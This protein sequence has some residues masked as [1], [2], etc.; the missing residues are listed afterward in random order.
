MTRRGQAKILDFG[1]AKLSTTGPAHVNDEGPTIAQ[2]ADLT[3]RG[4]TVGT[5]AY[6]S[7]EQ[8]RRLDLDARTDLFSFGVVLYEMATGHQPF[9]GATSAVIFEG[10]LSKAPVSPVRLNAALPP[11]LERVIN[12]AL[13]KDRTLRYQHASDLLT[14]LRCLRRGSGGSIVAPAA[15]PKRRAGFPVAALAARA[16]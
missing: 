13:E 10:I 5:V 16:C 15:A 1:L 9:A 7:P 8:A 4:S 12:K 2:K 6:M 14:D 3:D 11:D